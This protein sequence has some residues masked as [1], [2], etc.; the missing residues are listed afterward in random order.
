MTII[1]PISGIAQ[2][3]TPPPIASGTDQAT[4]TVSPPAVPQQEQQKTVVNKQVDTQANSAA[5]YEAAIQQ[6]AL[7]FKNTYAVSDTKFTIFKDA[8]G[9][10]IT[11]Y[12][13]LRDGSITYIP[14]PVLLRQVQ[15][16][17]NSINGFVHVAINA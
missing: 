4:P 10:Y 11:R 2:S 8:T 3:Y 7:S 13:S 12:T 5:Q 16:S 15:A 17:T 1:S 9:Q 6:A 14:Q